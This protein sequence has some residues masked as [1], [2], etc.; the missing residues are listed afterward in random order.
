MKNE[1]ISPHNG[2]T[3]HIDILKVD[4]EGITE[5]QDTVVDEHPLHVTVDGT[6][7]AT[8]MC[9]PEALEALVR[10]FL[11][12]EGLAK[13]GEDIRR[14]SI[15]GANAEA[16]VELA[17]ADELPLE[18]YGRR[19]VFSGCGSPPL[20]PRLLDS[21]RS[22]PLAPSPHPLPVPSLF[23]AM[24]ELQ[25]RSRLFAETGG[26]HAAAVYYNGGILFFREDVGRHNAVDKV[27]GELAASDTPRGE[28][29]L[30]CSGR[31]STDLVTKAAAHRIPVIASRSAP[32]HRAVEIAR[33]TDIGLAGFV[34]GSRMN[35]YSGSGRFETPPAGETSPGE[36]PPG[37]TP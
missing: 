8:L 19:T 1:S 15:D 35:I 9:L 16:A 5:T 21:L 22:K 13:S 25:Q 4:A 29:A 12:S 11:I 18:L 26:V 20:F 23:A 32:T 10:G 30:L 37:E 24:R 33:A 27:A 6:P 17:N 2:V 34:R 28:C 14:I 7:I 36:T 31:I 3:Q